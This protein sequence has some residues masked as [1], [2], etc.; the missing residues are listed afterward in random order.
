MS[1][2]L[3]KHAIVRPSERL[4]MVVGGYG[5]GKTEVCVNLAIALGALGA[6]GCRSRTWIS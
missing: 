2:N 4:L 6:A 3:E 1:Q 5:S